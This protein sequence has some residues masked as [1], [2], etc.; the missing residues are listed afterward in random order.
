MIL[1]GHA[2]TPDE[3]EVV[4]GTAADVDVM[5]TYVTSDQPASAT[6]MAP[7]VA[8]SLITTATTTVV[9]T[10]PGATKV[11]GV[12]F[13]NIRNRDSVDSTQVTVQ[14]DRNADGA[15]VVQL[16]SVT[17]APGEA[18]EWSNELGWY[19][20]AASPAAAVG[21]NKMTGSDQALGTSEV[22]LQNSAL[23]LA[24][25]G[26]PQIGRF[27]RWRF[28]VSKTA[29][30][31]ATPIMIIKTGTAG[32]TSDTTRLTFTWGAGTAAIDRAE[33]EVEAGF[34]A[35]GSGTSAVLRG[36][37]NMT[38]NLTTTGLSNAVKALQPA[39]SGGFDSTAAGLIIGVTWNAGAS[40]AQTLEHLV[41]DTVQY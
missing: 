4:T 21:T 12:T 13:L 15:D 3:L 6:T 38:S 5:V 11:H 20:M 40:G 22:Y 16:H 19:K 17:L 34:I 18:L 39:D 28:I 30:G 31:T 14:L 32:T 33:I 1:Q 7:D 27:Y 25:L 41:A 37:A 8:H 10:G 29:A 2:S 36:K 24:A 26:T 23:P 9:L 35:V